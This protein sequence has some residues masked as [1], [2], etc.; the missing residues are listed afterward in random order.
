MTDW[1][2]Y[3]SF[4]K[5]QLVMTAVNLAREELEREL[6][7]SRNLAYAHVLLTM[8]KDN[9]FESH[10]SEQERELLELARQPYLT[11]ELQK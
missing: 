8:L 6:S 11:K 10:L 4:E 1:E 2:D 5:K 3:T 7:K 9:K